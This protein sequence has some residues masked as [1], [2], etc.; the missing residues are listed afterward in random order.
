V[1]YNNPSVNTRGLDIF[2]DSFGVSLTPDIDDHTAF[3]K[4]AVIDVG[5][6]R[7]FSFGPSFRLRQHFH[8]LQMG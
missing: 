8:Q 7:P 3:S 6:S 5:L 1:V 2:G 4:A